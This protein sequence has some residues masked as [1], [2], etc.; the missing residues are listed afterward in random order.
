MLDIWT[1]VYNHIQKATH[2]VETKDLKL[3]LQVVDG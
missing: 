2:I 3:L 1:L